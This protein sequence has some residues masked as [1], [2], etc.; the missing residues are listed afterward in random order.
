MNAETC[1]WPPGRYYNVYIFIINVLYT[2]F[3]LKILHRFIY[4][5]SP[6]MI[7][8]PLC[9]LL[10]IL[11]FSIFSCKTAK[12]PVRPA[13]SYEAMKKTKLS[14]INIPISVHLGQM[15]TALNEEMDAIFAGENQLFDNDQKDF[16]LKV[17]KA[18]QLHLDVT[19]NAVSYDVPLDLFVKKDFGIGQINADG[20]V[21]LNFV[22]KFLIQPDWTLK[23]ETVLENY[24]WIKQPKLDLGIIRLPIAAVANRLVDR[25]R[26]KIAAIIDAQI[27]ENFILK[28]YVAD[29]W[30]RLQQPIPASIE[31]QL[32][33]K[34]EPQSIGMTGLEKAD[35]VVSATLVIETL[36]EASI[37]NRPEETAL[38]PLPDFISVDKSAG[39]FSINLFTAIPLD[40]LRTL[41]KKNIIGETYQSGKRSVTVEDL[42]IYGK[43]NKL[44]VNTILSGDYKGSIYMIGTPFYNEKKNQLEI[45]NLKYELS[46]KNFIQKS[47]GWLFQNKIEKT[48][49]ATMRYP[50]EENMNDYKRLLNQ[51]LANYAI[52]P[53]IILKGNMKDLSIGETYVSEGF[54][55]VII[56]S[57][58]QLKLTLKDLAA[59]NN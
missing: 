56:R 9:I 14:R 3:L 34:M 38:K 39:D 50:L 20:A 5:Q 4:N 29:A 37:G 47:M 43:D 32:W 46:S 54:I 49:E 57:D 12:A 6:K 58:G 21:T 16:E 53:G 44:V 22:T 17:T 7:R 26:T 23:T 8:F 40:S 35:S 2:F 42:E 19:T 59:L 24:D 31:N 48:I 41:V 28:D 1:L 51:S 25:S 30:N 36:A 10:S 15:E 11:I 45:D 13:A 18:D 33:V 27:R 52:T 55:H